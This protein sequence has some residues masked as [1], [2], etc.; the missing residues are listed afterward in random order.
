MLVRRSKVG[1]LGSCWPEAQFS[2]SLHESGNV[3]LWPIRQTV[4][5]SSS[6]FFGLGSGK[7]GVWYL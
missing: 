2:C 6:S 1:R 5:L 7:E 3:N 4:I